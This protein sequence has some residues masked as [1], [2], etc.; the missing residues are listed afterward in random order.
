MQYGQLVSDLE[1]ELLYV[2]LDSFV[3][4]CPQLAANT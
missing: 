3:L 2:E 4:D 1:K